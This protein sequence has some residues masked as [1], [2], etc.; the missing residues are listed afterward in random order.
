[1]VSEFRVPRS[2]AFQTHAEM[3]DEIEAALEPLLYGSMQHS[4]VVRAQFEAEFAAMM[5]QD[6]AVAVH[7]GTVGLFVAL[8][9]CGVGSGDE[10]ITVSNSDISTTGAIR[11]CGAIPI[12]C[13][14]LASD[15][16]IDP[17]LVEALITPKT[18]AIMPVDLHGHPANVQ[19]L[20][21]IADQHGLK[22]VEDAA[23][24][25]GAADYGKPLGAYADATI[26]SFAPFKPLGSVS[27]GAAVVT[28]DPAIAEKL[29]LLVGY[30]YD[31]D[32]TGMPIGHQRY[33]DEGYNVPL[34]GLQ[35]ALLLVKLP[36][37]EKWTEQRRAVVARYAEG[38][39][40]SPVVLPSLR[41]ESNPTFR[42]YTV[43][44]PDRERIYHHLR[45]NGV[46]VVLHYT[47]PIYHHPVYGGHLPGCEAL[48]NTDQLARDL[49]CLPVT[50]ELTES[51]IDYAVSTLRAAL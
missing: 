18:R 30:G 23:L 2:R 1:M 42:S 28:S 11:Q 16:T 51:D 46:E 27:N 35:A 29:R 33:I 49:I 13:D 38:L 24:A 12:V 40:D 45:E 25:A 19:A 4:Y 3:R 9:A 41:E 39:A 22:I 7:S 14:V 6:T 20:R 17:S 32:H 34:D 36:H 21:Q 5:A 31:P 44:V 43:C 47:P 8:K 26:Y 48:P 15:Y 37:L 50:P 10:V